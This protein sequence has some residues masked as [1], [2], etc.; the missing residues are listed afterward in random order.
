MPTL[1]RTVAAGSDDAEEDNDGTNFDRTSGTLNLV[2]SSNPANVRSVGLRFQDI[3]IPQ[4]SLIQSATMEIDAIAPAADDPRCTIHCH[5]IDNS[6]NFVTSATVIGRTRTTAS[7]SWIETSIGTGP[8]NTPN[9]ASAVQEVIDRPGWAAGNALTVILLGNG[10]A[11]L[12]LCDIAAFEDSDDDPAILTI[13][14]IPPSGN[15]GGGQG[16]GQGRGGGRGGGT[17]KPPDTPGNGP[18]G[19]GGF[20]KILTGS[21]KRNRIGIL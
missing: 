13:Q 3:Q 16:G 20:D 2:T 12:A 11:L 14:F 1:Q 6:P 17:G 8:H 7:T 4:S 10:T 5:D 18:G 9:F 15:S 21:K 19:I